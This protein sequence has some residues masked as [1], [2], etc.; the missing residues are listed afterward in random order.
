[1]P[2]GELRPVNCNIDAVVEA[3]FQKHQSHPSFD[4]HHNNPY[5]CVYVCVCVCV[6]VCVLTLVIVCDCTLALSSCEYIV[7]TCSCMCVC[8]CVCAGMQWCAALH[9]NGNSDGAFPISPSPWQPSGLAATFVSGALAFFC[10][11][12]LRT[13]THARTRTHTH[14]RT[15]A[16]TYTP[17]LKS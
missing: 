14:T 2:R 16:H 12:Q 17:K 9:F 1:M 5:L 10:V 4:K 15:R 13:H 8:V 11:P 7:C 3:G 6:C